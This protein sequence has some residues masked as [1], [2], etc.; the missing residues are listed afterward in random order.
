MTF[1]RILVAI[2]AALALG[3]AQAQLVK[4]GYGASDDNSQGLG[5]KRVAELVKARTAGRV[6]IATYGSGKLGT[7]AQM[8]SALQGGVTEMMVG[9]TSNL[10]G[11]I[12]EYALFDLPYLVASF[13]EADGLLDGPVGQA[14]AARL[15]A[16]GLVGLAYWE[17]GFR[18]VTNSKRAVARLED[19]QGLKIRVIPNPV[20]IESFKELG[21]NPVPLP[22]TELYGALE[23]RAVDAQE[24]GLG[25]IES[26][27]FYEVQK[28]LS[29]TGHSY[30]PYI[31][32]A[33]KKWFDKLSDA[34]RT[35]VREAALEAGAYQRKINR[36]QSA[37]LVGEMKKRGLQVTE[38]APAEIARLRDKAKAVHEKFTPQIGS[39]LMAQARAEIAKAGQ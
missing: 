2:A 36:E 28:F 1:Q 23:S 25:L 19:L 17:N 21:T 4:F 29:L 7:D 18:H 33:S 35:A 12:K 24:N 15:D 26:G 30:T 37:L 32:L 3:T 38:V 34:D 13:R 20:Y 5:A 39:K 6:N 22:Y 14:L 9:P 16:H 10:V 31:V 8:Q 27:R 11:V